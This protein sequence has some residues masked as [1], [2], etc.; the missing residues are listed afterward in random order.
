MNRFPETSAYFFNRTRTRTSWQVFCEPLEDKLCGYPW[1]DQTLSVFLESARA[2]AKSYTVTFWN[3]LSYFSLWHW[4]ELQW[5]SV[6]TII[7]MGWWGFLF[8]P[9]TL[10]DGE[11]PIIS[12]TTYLWRVVVQWGVFCT[13]FFVNNFIDLFEATTITHHDGL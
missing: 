6:A 4:R 7:N 13:Q 3:D 12:G 10:P 5:Y 8:A 2:L 11:C 1:M 9:M